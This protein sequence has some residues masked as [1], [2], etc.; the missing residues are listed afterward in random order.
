MKN[1]FNCSF[2]IYDP[3]ITSPYGERNRPI[4]TD[5]NDNFLFG[6]EFHKGVDLVSNNKESMQEVFC[7]VDEAD[8]FFVWDIREPQNKKELIWNRWGNWVCLRSI[9]D[10]KEYFQIFAHLRDKPNLDPL[11]KLKKGQ[12]IG[13]VG[14]TGWSTGKHLHWQIAE[15]HLKNHKDPLNYISKEEKAY[16]LFKNNYINNIV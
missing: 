8:V 7:N 3:V 10:G 13:F 16:A 11:A 15:E 6:K 12:I 4:K 5:E 14:S 1:K 2:P 9:V